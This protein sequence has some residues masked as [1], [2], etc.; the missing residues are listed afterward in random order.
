MNKQ[1]PALYFLKSRNAQ[2]K[3]EKLQRI[4]YQHYINKEKIFIH[5][6]DD[7]AAKFV[8]ELLWRWP[9]DSFL[10]HA[11][12][13]EKT[14]ICISDKSK[15]LNKAMV[16]INLR[17]TASNL[18]QNF[19][20]KYDLFDQSSPEKQKLSEQRMQEYKKNGIETQLL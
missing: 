2:E 10:P 15:N 7:F 5:V 17:S 12:N 11:I 19:S 8:D 1:A 9:K 6:N 16:L 4:I 18:M 20:F 13:S 3:I 14:Q